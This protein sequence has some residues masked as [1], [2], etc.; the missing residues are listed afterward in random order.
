M[1]QCSVLQLVLSPI[2]TCQTSIFLWVI[3]CCFVVSHRS[4]S[5]KLSE[6]IVILRNMCFICTGITL[7][8][9][10][11][12]RWRFCLPQLLYNFTDY[13]YIFSLLFHLFY[14]ISSCS[15]EALMFYHL[16]KIF[17]AT[18]FELSNFTKNTYIVLISLNMIF[19]VIVAILN[20]FLPF[21]ILDAGIYGLMTGVLFFGYIV[22]MISLTLTA[23]TKL[24][25]VY[26]LSN[27]EKL[28]HAI[29]KM[30]LLMMI[31]LTTTLIILI[32][33]IVY[34]T[35]PTEW[36]TFIANVAG[37]VDVWTNFLNVMLSFKIFDKYYTKWC[38]IM[39]SKC[40]KCCEFIV[41]GGA[42]VIQLENVIK[43]QQTASDCAVSQ[44]TENIVTNDFKQNE[45]E[46]KEVELNLALHLETKESNPTKI[47]RSNAAC[48]TRDTLDIPRQSATKS[49]ISSTIQTVANHLPALVNRITPLDES[50]ESI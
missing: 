37:S 25:K 39:D 7:L 45:I 12:I 35:N 26:R 23:I 1:S 6:T 31:S 21:Y 11:V 47:T 43:Q 44:N 5:Q 3:L 38:G 28:I 32:L 29:T 46:M 19:V 49:A 2:F 9:Y 24:I 40:H 8:L 16:I 10:N 34:S 18:T 14:G 48:T 27:K 42:D 50:N 22:I 17:N 15:V 4:K 41:L 30:T 36:N 33:N 13:Y 20:V